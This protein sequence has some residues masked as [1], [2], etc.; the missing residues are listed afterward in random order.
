MG[1]GGN[2]NN[3]HG[4]PMGMGISQ[5]MGMGG[6]GNVESHSR[7]SL[8][9]SPL[10]QYTLVVC[11]QWVRW[12]SVVLQNLHTASHDYVTNILR[13]P[14]LN[15]PYPVRRPPPNPTTS[16]RAVCGPSHPELPY[17]GLSR[18]PRARRVCLPYRAVRPAEWWPRC[19]AV[20]SEVP[21]LRLHLSRMVG[22]VVKYLNTQVLKYYLN[23]SP[24]QQ[25]GR[26]C[27]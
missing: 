26:Q 19:G 5:K 13:P 20:R 1:M 8:V 27:C 25:N 16:C 22:N 15:L 4:N 14:H 10:E 12:R 6:N 21:R 7:T 17:L 11:L 18:P 9:W 23:T 3:P 2:G 24:P